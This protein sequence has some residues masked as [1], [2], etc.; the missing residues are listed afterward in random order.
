M[1]DLW[2]ELTG[3]LKLSISRSA[4]EL[5]SDDEWQ[6]QDQIAAYAALT[7]WDGNGEPEGWYRHMRTGRRR[8][9]GDP[10]REYINP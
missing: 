9:D 2:W 3:T 8:P 10:T 4:D 5:G 6:Y 7:V 1:L